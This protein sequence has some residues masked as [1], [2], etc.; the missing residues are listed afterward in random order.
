MLNWAA[1]GFVQ[2]MISHMMNAT[3][4]TRTKPALHNALHATTPTYTNDL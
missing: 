1:W 2:G 4:N 3:S